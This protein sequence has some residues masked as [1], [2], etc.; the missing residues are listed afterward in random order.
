ML[1]NRY[2]LKLGRSI[3]RLGLGALPMGP[4][5][6]SLSP[7]EG[8]EVVRLAVESGIKFID[9]ATLYRTYEHIAAGLKGWKGEVTI[10]TKTHAQKDRCEAEKHIELALHALGRETIDIMLCHCARTGFTDELWGPTLDALLTARH[11]GLIRM[12]GISSHSVKNVRIAAKNPEID[13]I[14]PLIN[15]KGMGIID[16]TADDMLS[17]IGEAHSAGKFVYAMKSL[18]YRYSNGFT[19]S[20][21]R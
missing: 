19:M 14:H 1:E 16:G 4:L 7:Q 9:T 3:T 18:A 5:Q 6:R 11:K 12:V 2:I 10:A 8:A 15:I 17:A 13:V 21:L 20:N